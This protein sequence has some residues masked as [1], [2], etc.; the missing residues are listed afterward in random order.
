LSTRQGSP[1]PPAP[2]AILVVSDERFLGIS[3]E[4]RDG[5]TIKIAD[6]ERTVIDCLA[7]PK[8]SG[9]LFEVA[10]IVQPASRQHDLDLLV[11]ALRFNNK[12]LLQRLGY[13]LQLV[14]GETVGGALDDLAE[15]IGRRRAYLGR[16]AEFGRRGEYVARWG[17]STTL[18][19]NGS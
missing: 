4:T 5:L 16:L 2:P 3:D 18:A 12:S 1:P 13:L 17:L 19:K 8:R 9:G 15:S 6:H 7:L 11:Y 14:G 10:R